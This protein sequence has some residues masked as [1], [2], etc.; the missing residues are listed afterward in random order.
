[1]RVDA[2]CR[3]ARSFKVLMYPDMQSVHSQPN[4]DVLLEII[5]I[6]TEIAKMGLDL[7]GVMELVAQRT[8]PLTGAA[9]AVVELAEGD[10]MVYRAASGITESQLGLRLKRSSSL[11]G[12][13]MAEREILRCDDAE[14]DDRVDRD[15]C[16]K[17]GL[18]SMLV[19]PL[20]HLDDTVG[21][22]KV[23]SPAI[24]AF[25][26]ADMQTLGLM[27]ELIAA[28]MFHAAR[29]ETNELYFR[30]THDAL[31]GLA[32]RAL[33]YDRLRQ[34][35]AQAQRHAE[36]VGILNLDMD[37]LKPINDRYGHRAGDSA[38]K[39]VASRIRDESRRSDTIARLGGDEFGV[40]LSRVA[41]RA[42]AE[43]QASRLA[44]KITMPFQF[45]HHPLTL[46][47]SVGVA[48]FPDDGTDV[49]ALLEKADQSMYQVKRTRQSTGLKRR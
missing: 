41:D 25:S 44:S 17:V 6:Q 33:F 19:V 32:N 18:H 48:I 28:A 26:E 13:C 34:N 15:A 8:Q 12:R 11:S 24:G 45:E 14:T 49:E 29:H 21:V 3:S 47:A 1:M 30:A 31:T 37:G 22:L 2:A 10:E 38:L 16:R 39:E 4:P 9:G 20:N 35:L 42:G 27:A 46:S 5:K 23:V 7:A 36:R 43:Q 40:I